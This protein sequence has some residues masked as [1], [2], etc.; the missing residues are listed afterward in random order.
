MKKHT[1]NIIPTPILKS[2]P[3]ENYKIGMLFR[4]NL[5]QRV[6]PCKQFKFSMAM[7]LHYTKIYKEIY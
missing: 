5:I 4:T 3:T 2:K 7:L 1:T 6:K